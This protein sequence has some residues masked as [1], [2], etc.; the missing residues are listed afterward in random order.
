MPE[1][2]FEAWL[3]VG[4]ASDSVKRHLAAFASLRDNDTGAKPENFINRNGLKV[5]LF[6]RERV[7]HQRLYRFQDKKNS[8]PDVT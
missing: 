1:F 6:S 3:M 7:L 2:I 8:D 4:I 5:H